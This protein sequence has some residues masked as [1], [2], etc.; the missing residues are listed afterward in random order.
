[1]PNELSSVHAPLNHLH[2]PL[3]SGRPMSTAE[4]PVCG[5]TIDLSGAKPGDVITCEEC[6]ARLRVTRRGRRYELVEVEEE[7]GEEELG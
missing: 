7:E 2:G 1:M 6:G 5:A 3:T 4:C